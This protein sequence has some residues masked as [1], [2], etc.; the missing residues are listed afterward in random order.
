MEILK[1]EIPNLI[2]L[3][4]GSVK[5]IGYKD[6]IIGKDVHD[7]K[8]NM[9]KICFNYSSEKEDFFYFNSSG[10]CLFYYISE[11]RA[12]YLFKAYKICLLDSGITPNKFIELITEVYVKVGLGFY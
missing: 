8:I 4:K 6:N 11:D 7:N 3:D 9:T 2:L 1:A 10:K 12:E 5:K